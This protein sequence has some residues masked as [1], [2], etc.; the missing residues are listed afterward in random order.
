M[1]TWLQDFTYKTEISW[2]AFLIPGLIA[3][4]IA[5]LTVS[6]QSIRAALMK[7]VDSLRSE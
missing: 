3:V 6:Y 4:M 2:Q 5:L 7:P 1:N